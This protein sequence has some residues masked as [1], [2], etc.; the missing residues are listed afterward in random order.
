MTSQRTEIEQR[1]HDQHQA[2]LRYLRDHG[3]AWA[4]EIAAAI[5]AR[6]QGI[7]ALLMGRGGVQGTMEIRG[8]AT[9]A[10]GIR[11]DRQWRFSIAADGL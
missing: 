2:A 8:V 7:Q 9:K 10:G 4:N 11:M 3:P 1:R 5:G 6:P